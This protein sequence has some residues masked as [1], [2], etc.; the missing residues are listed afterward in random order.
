MEEVIEN[1]TNQHSKDMK[2]QMQHMEAL[3]K[4]MTELIQ[5]MKGQNPT[6]VPAPTNA[7]TKNER[8]KKRKDYQK[9]LANAK[10]CTHCKSKH[11]NRTDDQCWKLEAN[12]ATSPD[13]WK[14]VKSK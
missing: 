10:E 2:A 6:P 12:A 7:G 3:A 9:T 8:T 4:S 1:I 11:P 13:G 5:G 14:S